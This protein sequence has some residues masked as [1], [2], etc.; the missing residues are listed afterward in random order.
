MYSVSILLTI[1]SKEEVTDSTSSFVGKNTVGDDYLCLQQ[2]L[3]I[4]HSLY[5]IH[6]VTPKFDYGVL[7]YPLPYRY[8]VKL[9]NLINQVQ[10]GI[11]AETPSNVV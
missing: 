4:F 6:V 9:T 2:Y 10:S 1:T 7:F 5:R 3:Y 11:V 8:R